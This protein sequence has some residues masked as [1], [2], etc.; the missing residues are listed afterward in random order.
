LRSNV[1]H[2]AGAWIKRKKETMM[3]VLEKRQLQTWTG[4]WFTDRR[5]QD[6][7]PFYLTDLLEDFQDHLTKLNDSG[8]GG[9]ETE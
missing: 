2:R 4:R 9:R 6:V 5:P 7:K 8:E 1:A 3:K